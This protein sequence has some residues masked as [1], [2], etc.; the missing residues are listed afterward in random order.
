MTL[1]VKKN[2][3]NISLKWIKE[4]DKNVDYIQNFSVHYLTFWLSGLNKYFL[5][6]FLRGKS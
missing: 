3:W 4:S 2:K 6:T 1:E 5:K